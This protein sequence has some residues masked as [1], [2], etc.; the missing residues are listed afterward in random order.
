M[1]SVASP[2]AEGRTVVDA[3]RSQGIAALPVHRL[4]RDVSGAMVLAKDAETRALL[5]DL[6]RG[7][8]VTKTYWALVQGRLPKPPG[9]FR[10]PIF[11]AGSH[12]RISPR[13]K[14]AITRWRTRRR[15][16]STTEVEVDLET[17]RYN[18]IRL[19]FAHAGH[20]LV[21]ERKYARG[22]D[23]PL[24]AKRVALHA[25]RLAFPHP[26][27]PGDVDVSA[28]LPKDL[29][30]LLEKAERGCV[31]AVRVEPKARPAAGRRRRRSRASA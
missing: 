5:E 27:G 26:A 9:T 11:D 12:A 14:P 16:E 20:P 3:L 21:G 31:D 25:E 4:D 19:H 22:K 13:G 7:R 29:V 18:Q 30:A 8:K 15:F 17:G 10:F 1:L 2:G 6:F 28:P 23:D 24:R